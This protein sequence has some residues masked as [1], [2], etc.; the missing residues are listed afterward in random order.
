MVTE[1]GPDVAG[2]AVGD[3]VMGLVRSRSDRVVVADAR[4]VAAIP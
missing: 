2:L 3:R 1:V 4:T